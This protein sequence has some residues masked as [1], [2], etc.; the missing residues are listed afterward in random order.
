MINENTQGFTEKA[1]ENIKFCKYYHGE[2]E[3]PYK[4]NNVIK[5]NF[6]WGE[7]MFVTNQIDLDDWMK[8]AQEV[9]QNLNPERR[10]MVEAKYSI[11]QIAILVYIE[12]LYSKWN[13]YDSDL[14]WI[15]EY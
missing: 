7:M 13:P 10:K 9:M 2:K 1:K 11:E 12:M 6:W 3:N 4:G 8:T 14:S 5:S 15:F